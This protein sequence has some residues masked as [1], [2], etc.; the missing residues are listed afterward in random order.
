MEKEHATARF[1][2][3]SYLKTLTKQSGVYRM[4]GA[5]DKLL[6]IGKARNLKNRVTSY[7]RAAGLSTKT[8]ALVGRIQRIEVTITASETEALLL[9]QSLIKQHRP[10]YNIVLRDDKSYPYIYLTTHQEYPRLAFHRGA[11]KKVGKYFGPY[12]SASAVR[13]SLNILQRLFQIRQCD[14]SFFRNRSR[15]CLQYQIKRCT[16]PCTGKISKED[17]EADVRMAELFLQGRNTAVLN[18]AKQAMQKASD[19]LEFEKAAKYRDQNKQLRKIQEQQFVHASSGDVDIFALKSASNI[20]CVQ[21]LFIRGGRLLG[22]RTWFPKDQLARK[23][24]EF[25]S[26]FLSQY[27]FG[28]IE[29]EIP[30]VLVT[31]LKLTSSDAMK[32]ALE[33]KAGR[34]VE[35]VSRVRTQRARWLEMAL[36]N[37]QTNLNNFMAEKRNVFARFVA[38]QELMQLEDVP[39]RLE[40]FDISHTSGEATVASCVVFDATGPLRSDYRRFNIEGIQAGD[41]YAAMTQAL[42]RRY[43]RLKAGEGKL[44]DVLVIDG[45]KGQIGIAQQVLESFQI[46]NVIILGVAKGPTR[47]A[48]LETLYLAGEGELVAP[49]NGAALHLI[50]HIRDEAHRFAIAGH[51]QRRGKKRTR[52]ELEGIPGIGAKRRKELLGHFGSISVLKGASKAEIA[53]V[54]GLSTKLATEIYSRLHLE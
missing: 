36:E 42:T 53:K 18:H 31:N 21:G 7:F 33:D 16:A 5:E 39:A 6:Y 4:Y 47:K 26:A 51:R 32:E 30:R 29:R 24:N 12:P 38:L 19:N 49:P 34:K 35:L 28:G 9:E 10:P 22:N 52:S 3:E 2:H 40:C 14:E 25:L 46:D 23:E 44:P 54:K 8:M 41:D 48:G 1:E 17:Y 45:G 20:F 13:D 43:A 11:R 27:Y 37:A 15:P 50:Q